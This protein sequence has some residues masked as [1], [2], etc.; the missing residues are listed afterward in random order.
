MA[1][2]SGINFPTRR[3]VVTRVDEATGAETVVIQSTALANNY[4]TDAGVRPGLMDNARTWLEA[5]PGIYRIYSPCNPPA[6]YYT[7]DDCVW[8]SRV[9]DPL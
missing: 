8:D 9:S 4:T 7:D 5:N 6:V 1:P 3:F 2:P